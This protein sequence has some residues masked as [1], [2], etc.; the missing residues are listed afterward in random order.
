MA[1]DEDEANLN[2]LE[3]LREQIRCFLGGFEAG[4]VE[5]LERKPGTT[6]T[7]VAEMMRNKIADLT[8]TLNR[9]GRG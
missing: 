4:H 6:D 5:V 8:A 7:D 3:T 9:H 2:G 1:D